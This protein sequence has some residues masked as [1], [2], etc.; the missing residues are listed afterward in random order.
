SDERSECK[1]VSAQPSSHERSECK[2]VSAQPSTRGVVMKRWTEV[3]LFILFLNVTSFAQSSATFAIKDG[4]GTSLQTDGAASSALAV[5][6]AKVSTDPGAQTPAGL[7]II[8]FRENNVLVSEAGVPA[9]G[10]ITSGRI[11][12]AISSTI[13]TGIA[14][15]NPTN[16][17]ATITFFFSDS[18]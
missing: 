8:D 16:Q 1:R 18:S 12:A 5:G 17:T 9:S 13:N 3:L 15:A 11:Y 4:G 6:Y 14:I 7:A 10:V 2:R